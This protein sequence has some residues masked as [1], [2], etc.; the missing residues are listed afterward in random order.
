MQTV[1]P[2]VRNGSCS[3]T[4][5]V[6]DHQTLRELEKDVKRDRLGLVIEVGARENCHVVDVDANMQLFQHTKTF[7]PLEFS[8]RECSVNTGTQT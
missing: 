6:V 7:V 5:S 2:H 3:G 1:V 4:R 8:Q